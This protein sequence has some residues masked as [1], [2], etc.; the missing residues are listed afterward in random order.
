MIS[1]SATSVPV[2]VTTKRIAPALAVRLAG[3]QPDSL[4][5]T[6]TEAPPSWVAG[7]DV[8]HAARDRAIRLTATSRRG[9]GSKGAS[10]GMV[11]VP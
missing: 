5:E 2:F 10:G 6:A 3:A 7:A 4:T 9:R 11:G 8:P 1:N